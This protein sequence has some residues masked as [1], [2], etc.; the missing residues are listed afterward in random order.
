M[1]TTDYIKRPLLSEKSVLLAQT[2][3]KYTFVVAR[4]ANKNQIKEG[5]EALYGVNVKAVNTNIGYR[6]KKST[7]RKRMKTMVAPIKKAVVTLAQGQT[8]G[9]F[10]FGESQTS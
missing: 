10:D 2:E 9:V 7:G 4:E 8:I 5:I 3:N 6:I 1:I